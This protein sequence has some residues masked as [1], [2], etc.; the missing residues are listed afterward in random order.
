MACAMCKWSVVVHAVVLAVGL[1]DAESAR[2]SGHRRFFKSPMERKKTEATD[3]RN[4]RSEQREINVS[5]LPGWASKM[6]TASILGVGL[7][8]PGLLAAPLL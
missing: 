8:P 3:Q 2:G 7:V 5:F 4:V 6:L 1:L